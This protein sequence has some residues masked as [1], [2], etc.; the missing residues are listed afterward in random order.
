MNMISN[1]T[2][3]KALLKAALHSRKAGLEFSKPSTLN[4]D[5]KYNSIHILKM[6]RNLTLP[7]I[8]VLIELSRKRE[9]GLALLR[10]N[11]ID[12]GTENLLAAGKVKQD[13][14]LSREASLVLETF[15]TAA[16]AFLYYKINNLEKAINSLYQSIE[17]LQALHNFFGYE[18]EIRRIH[19]AKNI[20]RA[21]SFA[22]KVKAAIHL[23][24]DLLKYISGDSNGWPLYMKEWKNIEQI[25][26]EEKL[27]ISDQILNEI[28]ILVSNHS[29]FSN[30]ISICLVDLINNIE[31]NKDMSKVVL[32]LKA[33]HALTIN[34]KEDFLIYAIQFFKSG[35]GFLYDAWK[36]LEKS[37][38][39][40]EMCYRCNI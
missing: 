17:T 18:A 4:L 8:A 3:L 14:I 26:I 29:I 30:H 9:E 25:S 12:E 6:A 11:I 5:N 16:E 27:V 35:S 37:V 24:C 2:E 22:G 1:R 23:S 19:L 38:D 36:Q 39:N 7:E 28:A 32:W 40:I 10:K 31:H 34:R 33:Y 15:Q 13:I 21:Q 20:I